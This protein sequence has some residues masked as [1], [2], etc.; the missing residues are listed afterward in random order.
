[1]VLKGGLVALV[2][3]ARDDE[4]K[5]NRGT[6]DCTATRREVLGFVVLYL[7]TCVR[8]VASKGAFK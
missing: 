1:V 3:A 4:K 8:N 2:E 6:A 5:D 7:W